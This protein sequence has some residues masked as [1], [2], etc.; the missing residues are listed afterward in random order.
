M[1]K[2]ITRLGMV[3]CL[4]LLGCSE[5][6]R[7]T[8]TQDNERFS[9]GMTGSAEPVSSDQRATPTTPPTARQETK[10][11]TPREAEARSGKTSEQEAK[12]KPD[13]VSAA[14]DQ[15][16]KEELI[17]I[18]WYY[19]YPPEGFRLTDGKD[20]RLS[21]RRDGDRLVLHYKKTTQSEFRK[22]I[23]LCIWLPGN[24]IAQD[25]A[26]ELDAEGRLAFDLVPQG[27]KI[28]LAEEALRP[29]SNVIAIPSE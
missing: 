16:Q 20:Y 21:L 13:T 2:Q 29:L 22:K 19:I 4:L 14:A 28:Y 5:Q 12:T 18:A 1:R 9:E 3:F 26:N 24:K 25:C 15:D 6:Q 11:G 8:A 27:S 23:R 10:A 7:G 17:I